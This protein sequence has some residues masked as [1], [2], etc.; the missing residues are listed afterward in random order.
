MR[1]PLIAFILLIFLSGCA[2]LTESQQ[3]VVTDYAKATQS[4]ADYPG[5]LIR[6]Y[7]DL[8]EEISL[9]RSPMNTNPKV[10][11]TRIQELYKGKK[12]LLKKAEKLDLT[13]KILKA[14]AKNLEILATTDY[15]DNLKNSSNELALNI[16]SLTSMYNRS[17]D[18]NMPKGFGEV[19]AKTIQFVGTRK[20]NHDRA[21]LVKE[22]VVKGDTLIATFSGIAKQFL[23][24]KVEQEWLAGLDD[25]LKNEHELIRTLLSSDK[26]HY[27]LVSYNVMLIDG[28]VA[29]LY[30]E[31]DSLRKLCKSLK[32]SIENISTVHK[33]VMKSIQEKRKIDVLTKELVIFINDAHN[34]AE[35][36][37]SK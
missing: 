8:R 23:E 3:Q 20:L 21:E 32:S 36:V 26:Q 37:E 11:A 16:D 6:K 30:E 24:Q 13:F 7:A 4:Y 19:M 1:N 35:I 22:Y 27:P 5:V 2:S 12:M 18:T 29:G 9:L 25:H 28:K 31:I 34:L 33:S 17:F 10:A 15:A 14:Y